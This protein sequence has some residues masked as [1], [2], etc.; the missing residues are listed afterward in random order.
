MK[1]ILY[2]PLTLLISIFFGIM[3]GMFF[4]H[5]ESVLSP[6]N[7][8]YT[9]L[10]QMCTLPV[11]ISFIT[12]SVGKIFQ[13]D[14]RSILGKV[15]VFAFVA[16]IL[17]AVLG[18]AISLTMKGFLSPSDQDKIELINVSNVVNNKEISDTFLER[19]IYEK[20]DISNQ[21]EFSISDFITETVPS[22]I[23]TALSENK[24]LQI[25]TFFVILGFMLLF[26]EESFAQPI[27]NLLQGIS[28][29]LF[30]FINLL[31][32]FLPFS[33]FITMLSL[34]SAKETLNIFN[35]ILNFIVINYIA[36][37]ILIII[38]ALIIIKR[39]RITIKQH[40][41]AMKRIFFL[42][43]GTG[44][45][46]IVLPSAIEDA[47]H[48]NGMDETTLKS[49]LPVGTLFCSHGNIITAAITSVYAL[50]LYGNP[51]DFKSLAIIISSSLL[52]AIAYMAGSPIVMILPIVLQP[53][54]IP[55]DIMIL[56][57]ASAI[58]FYSGILAFADMYSI[59]AVTSLV[60]P[61]SKLRHNMQNIV[62]VTQDDN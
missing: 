10:L 21:N 58:P 28:E 46:F 25:I 37:G 23:F 4:S 59:L 24:I 17:S 9:S 16:I 13:K 2:S 35:S 15:L 50:M 26:I 6:I 54:G 43:L 30:K 36:L 29:A 45:S 14:F 20:N 1:K 11:V 56:I 40:L 53:L 27:I 22:N 34:F 48:K 32:M 12:L 19:T 51:I 8:M 60:T 38:S 42:S 31:C 52:F 62:R 61:K 47:V 18:F 7:N 39:T 33:I 55:A 3:A 57:L 5:L 44:V 41:K 49:F